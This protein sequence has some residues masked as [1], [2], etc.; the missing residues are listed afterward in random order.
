[1]RRP[2]LSCLSAF[3]LLG[4]LLPAQDLALTGVTL[5]DGDGS[6][7]ENAVILISGG[8]VVGRG[9][10]LALPAG[11]TAVALDGCFATPALID[12]G[13]A[14]GLPRSTENEEGR[15]TTPEIAAADALDLA[16][17]AFGA[18]LASG[19]GC[20][21]ILPG[22]RN[23]IAGTAAV[24]RFVGP[25]GRPELLSRHAGLV[26]AMGNEPAAGNARN[27]GTIR[28]RRP[29]TRMGTVWL[30]RQAF[31]AA[32][33]AE[34]E[35]TPATLVLREA[36]AGTLPMR[37]TA[38]PYY[39]I[40]A[41][42]SLAGELGLRIAALDE[43]REAWRAGPALVRLG[44]PVVFPPPSRPSAADDVEPRLDD[45]VKT[46]RA[47]IPIALTTGRG[48]SSRSL[49]EEARTAV[50]LGLSEGLAL[51]AITSIP[52]RILGLGERL[53]TLAP[54]LEADL[55][56]WTADPFGPVGTVRCVL[57]QGRPVHGA[58]PERTGGDQ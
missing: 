4:S 49:I 24:V 42:L 17:P 41:A 1:M 18:A 44:I 12:P 19:V 34:A 37:I 9:A 2:A 58:L 50:R 45:L 51:R 23:V 26:A 3:A 54:G 56:I 33:A 5:L 43:S 32:K 31:L 22:A 28:F 6:R 15:E 10:G 13:T 11:F 52:A 53:G 29:T 7:I 21:G 8:K 46:A 27:P 47:G 14:L 40:D 35:G 36:L 30:F 39:D 38:R 25:E 48:L 20:V 55:T 57:V 16:D